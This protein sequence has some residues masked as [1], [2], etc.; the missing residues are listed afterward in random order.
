M[1]DDASREEFL[2]E[3]GISWADCDCQETKPVSDIA[4]CSSNHAKHRS[5]WSCNTEESSVLV[6][7]KSLEDWTSERG[8][9]L[10]IL[11]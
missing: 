6:Q 8:M 2:E 1:D 3:H 9:S 4:V 11:L 7:M 5:K 10:R